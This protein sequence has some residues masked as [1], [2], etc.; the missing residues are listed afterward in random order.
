VAP[1]FTVADGADR[2]TGMHNNLNGRDRQCAIRLD[3]LEGSGRSHGG[4]ERWLWAAVVVAAAV[5]DQ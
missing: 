1:L 3:E 2:R 4:I 5:E